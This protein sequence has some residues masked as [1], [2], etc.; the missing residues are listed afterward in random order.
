[1]YRLQT[2]SCIIEHMWSNSGSSSRNWQK[3]QAASD[4]F[5]ILWMIQLDQLKS[6]RPEEVEAVVQSYPV[7]ATVEPRR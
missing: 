5:S 3:F 2:I 1:M 6:A 4:T 7:K